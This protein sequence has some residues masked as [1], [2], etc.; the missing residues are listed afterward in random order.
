MKENK[1]T[2][3]RKK[4][5]LSD[6]ESMYNRMSEQIK[7]YDRSLSDSDRIARENQRRYDLLRVFQELIDSNPQYAYLIEPLNGILEELEKSISFGKYMINDHTLF[8]LK[9]RCDLLR[10]E[11]IAADSDYKFYSIDE[12]S[13]AIAVIEA[14]LE[15][16]SVPNSEELLFL[17]REIKKKKDELRQL[18]NQ[19]D[20]KRINNVSQNIT[21]LYMSAKDISDIVSDDKVR[22][23]FSILY[24]KRGNNLQPQIYDNGE[25]LVNYYVGSMARHTLIQLCGYL[26]FL[27]MITHEHLCPIIPFFV[28]DHISK[29][30]DKNNAKAIGAVLRNFYKVV[31]KEEIQIILMDDEP[32]DNLGLEVDYYESLTNE[33]KTG[34]NPFYSMPST[35]D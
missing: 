1:K 19:N 8:Q 28:V 29:P 14:Y 6:L 24:Q 33:T 26:S 23:G 7:Q 35:T 34:F 12:K 9:K 22:D 10:Q 11:I 3:R 5:L 2:R 30:F 18:Q 20:E 25:K 4:R 31:D 17:K 21:N 32:Y 16:D 15:N 13:K 27:R